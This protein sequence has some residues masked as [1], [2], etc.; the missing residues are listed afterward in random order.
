MTDY[1]NAELKM[2]LEVSNFFK[3]NSE[4]T[5]KNQVIKKHIEK[6]N[7][8]ITDLEK[9]KAKQEVNTTGYAKEKREAKALLAKTAYKLSA[10]VRSFATDT[11]NDPL[12][13]KF[14][15]PES[16]IR[17]MSDVGIVNYT[18]TLAQAIK[19]NQG[20]LKNY[21][22]TA[23]NLTELNTQI[24]EYEN[25]LLLPAEQRKEKSVATQNIKDIIKEINN[26]LNDSVDNDMMQYSQS[27]PDLY[28]KYL[29]IREIDDSQTTAL[30]IKGTVT[31]ADTGKPLQ[32]VRVT[33]KFKAG[34]D[35]A[36]SVKSTSAKGNYQFK[37]LPDGKCT[38]TFEL[39]Y[40][41]SVSIDT[42]VHGGKA[43]EVSVVIKRVIH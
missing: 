16:H 34:A 27:Q 5:S 41:E 35:Y 29:K 6:L 11:N 3:T 26:L 8:L 12:F 18:K 19:D 14:K 31:D 1:Q 24:T 38:L 15:E 23:D 10:G 21:G 40:Y 22:I 20:N 42:A 36:E 7:L 39:E 30:S 4:L 33:Y 37:G 25:L 43:T 9:N 32:Y 13:N 17:K 2:F 28:N